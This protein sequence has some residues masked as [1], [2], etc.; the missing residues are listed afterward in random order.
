MA[1]FCRRPFGMPRTWPGVAGAAGA[2][3]NSMQ[4]YDGMGDD[5]GR[6]AVEEVVCRRGIGTS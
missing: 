1:R 2:W 6:P 5:D 3:S 4:T